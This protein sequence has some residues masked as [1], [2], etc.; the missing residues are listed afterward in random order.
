MTAFGSAVATVQR[1]LT[2][3]SEPDGDAPGELVAPARVAEAD[4][5]APCAARFVI[6]EMDPQRRLTVARTIS[7][8]P[9]GTPPS[10][11]EKLGRRLDKASSATVEGAKTAVHKAL[12]VGYLAYVETEE[13]G[14]IHLADRSA[15]DIWEWWA[16]SC[17]AMLED[18]GI[19][20]DWATMVRGMGR[21][22]LV[23]DLKALGLARFLGG[24]KIHQL[25]MTYAQAGVHLRLAQSDALPSAAFDQ[26]VSSRREDPDRPWRYEDYPSD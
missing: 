12:A 24:S 14:D 19:P 22:L 2:E 18:I 20:K 1:L 15:E 21:D 4:Q 6:G 9:L 3:W 5:V 11:A 10:L 7:V 13:R 25:G 23:A 26:A 17:R 16:P 8:G